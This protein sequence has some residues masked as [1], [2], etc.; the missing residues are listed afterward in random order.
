MIVAGRTTIRP[1]RPDDAAFIARIILSA[2]RGPLP[3]GWCDIALDRGEPECLAFIARLAVARHRS[4]Y[5][6]AHFLIAEVD[7]VPAAALC[8]MPA[9]GTVVAARAAIEEVAAET[10]IDAAG[11]LQRGAYAR[12]CW[13]Q[14]GEGDWLIEHV[15]RDKAYRG[16]GLVQELIGHALAAG[17][18]AGYAQASISF[19]IDNVAAERCYAKAGFA[20]AEEKRDAAFEAL[21]GAPGFRR[22]ARAM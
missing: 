18:A 7:D 11:V 5:H 6:V 22:F 8:A 17:K 3:R 12:H 19:L 21:T 13:V 16:G 15:A 1:A 2:Q 20:F 9:S 4:W 10:D 14:G